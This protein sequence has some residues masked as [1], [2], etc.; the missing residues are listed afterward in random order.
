MLPSYHSENLFPVKNC[1]QFGSVPRHNWA[2]KLSRLQTK[3]A[4]RRH[5]T[6]NLN[7]RIRDRAFLKRLAGNL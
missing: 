3:I 7:E 2:N 1:N 5:Y 6:K 4:C